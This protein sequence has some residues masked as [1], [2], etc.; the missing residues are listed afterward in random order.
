MSKEYAYVQDNQI[1]SYPVFEKHIIARGHPFSMYKKV[2]VKEN[3]EALPFHYLSHELV[4]DKEK[5]I[6]VKTLSNKPQPVDFILE[7][8]YKGVDQNQTL[9]ITD[10]DPTAINV[11]FSQMVNYAQ[12]RLDDFAAG[13]NYDDMLSLITYLDSAVPKFAQEAQIGKQARDNTWLPLITFMQNIQT[14]TAPIP[15]KMKDIVDL[16]PVLTWN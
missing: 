2:V 5:D 11:V 1:K 10:I 13:K 14:G 16:L 4:Y 3:V 12:K 7:T 9:S 8:L 15:R 6:V